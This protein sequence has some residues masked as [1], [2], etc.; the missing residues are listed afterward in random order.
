[1]AVITTY[2]LANTVTPQLDVGLYVNTQK[3]TIASPFPANTDNVQIFTIQRNC[4]MLSAHLRVG[5]TLGTGATIQLQRNR[6]G[7]R[8]N[9]TAATTAAA[10]GVVT[11]VAIGPLDLQA[12]DIIELLVGGADITASAAVEID[13]ALQ[14]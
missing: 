8:V 2:L 4:R 13:M 14:H 6:G 1:M 10:A 11:S 12:G 5:A 9:L 3:R 7:T